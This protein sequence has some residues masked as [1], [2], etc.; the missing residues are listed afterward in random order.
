M[1]KSSDRHAAALPET[2][3]LYRTKGPAWKF[4]WGESGFEHVTKQGT[5]YVVRG[6]STYRGIWIGMWTSKG[7]WVTIERK[8]GASSLHF[9]D[10]GRYIFPGHHE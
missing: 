6:P 10:G 1:S 4:T 8:I 9:S 3:I 5:R 7:C 2:C